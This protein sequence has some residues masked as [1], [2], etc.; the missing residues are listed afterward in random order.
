MFRIL[1]VLYTNKYGK[2]LGFT[3]WTALYFFYHLE[4][5]SVDLDFTLVQDISTEEIIS[6]KQE[7][8]ADLQKQL[9][10]IQIK[11]DGTLKNSI[12]YRAQYGGSKIIKIEISSK[13]YDNRYEIKNLSWLAVQVMNIEYMFAHKLCAFFSRYQQRDKIANRDLFDI[14]F[15][16]S[17]GYLPNGE[18]LQQ[19]SKILFG[20][21]MNEAQFI[22][23]LLVFLRTHQKTIQ[24]NILDGIGE[25]IN[26]GKKKEIKTNLLQDIINT[27]DFYRQ[28]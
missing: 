19:R 2:L 28:S 25:L 9:P 14:G 24:K 23:S 6:M 13:I 17:K 5:F 10:D 27:L 18:I 8:L 1:K 21:T 20:K 11:I 22:E 15:L 4:R 12:R 7:L 16:L 26:E 3:W